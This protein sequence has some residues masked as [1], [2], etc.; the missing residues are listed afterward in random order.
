MIA[1]A[2]ITPR[3]VPSGDT[4]LA[5]PLGMNGVRF[6]ASKCGSATA[7]N[8]ASATSFTATSTAFSVALSFVPSISSPATTA[9][10]NTAGTLTSPPSSGPCVSATGKPHG[11]SK[12]EA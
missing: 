10:M 4:D 7:T 2:A 12:A 3:S 8:T 9:M 11:V 6:A 5:K 1:A